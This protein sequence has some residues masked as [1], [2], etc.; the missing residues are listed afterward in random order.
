MAMTRRQIK[1]RMR[2]KAYERRRNVRKNN[3]P[4]S[5]LADYVAWYRRFGAEYGVRFSI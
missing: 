1:A 2:R 4:R 5:G 3:V